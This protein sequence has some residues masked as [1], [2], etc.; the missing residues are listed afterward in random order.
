MRRLFERLVGQQV[1]AAS[2]LQADPWR[3]SR[4]YVPFLFDPPMIRRRPEEAGRLSDNPRSR[5]R[6]PT[7]AT[8][9]A[10]LAGLGLRIGEAA[11]LQCGDVDLDR[12]ALL[13]RDSK[14]GKSRP[15]PFGP[16]L[17]Q[18][19]RDYL[20]L[21]V[22][23]TDGPSSPAPAVL[24]DG[25]RPPSTN[26]IRNVFRDDLLPRLAFEARPELPLPGF[27]GR[28]IPL[29]SRRR[30]VGTA[31]AWTLRRD[32]MTCRRSWDTRIRRAPR[33]I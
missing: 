10:V 17:S 19:L 18:R 8:L 12:D 1:M 14:F 4:R 16:R 33:S 20:A 26:T 6:G 32:C 29:P 24:L 11:R 22:A 7:Y 21:R 9:F 30:R 23:V 27:M 31:R 25:R 3:E 13:I 15:A 28:G 5:L 2:P